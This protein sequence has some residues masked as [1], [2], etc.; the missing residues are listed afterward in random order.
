[1]FLQLVEEQVHTMNQ[2]LLQILVVLAEAEVVVKAIPQQQMELQEHLDKETLVVMD[3][4]LT[5]TLTV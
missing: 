2:L 3:Q 1:L 4:I 5:H